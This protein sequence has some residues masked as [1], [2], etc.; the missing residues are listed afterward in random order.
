MLVLDKTSYSYITGEKLDRDDSCLSDL[1]Y[2]LNRP[3]FWSLMSK[4]VS[5]FT[6]AVDSLKNGRFRSV[7]RTGGVVSDTPAE[8]VSKPV[9]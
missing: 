6:N 4:P 7:N 8:S 3:F 1:S 2:R 5:A 9:P